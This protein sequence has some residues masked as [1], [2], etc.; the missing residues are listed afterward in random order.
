MT[1]SKF[2]ACLLSISILATPLPKRIDGKRIGGKRINGE[3]T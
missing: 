1:I 3:S 2:F